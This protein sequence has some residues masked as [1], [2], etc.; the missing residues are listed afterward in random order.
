MI[1]KM[2]KNYIIEGI[3]N[4]LKTKKKRYTKESFYY[5]YKEFKNFSYKVIN[6]IPIFLSKIKD[7]NLNLKNS[8]ITIDNEGTFL[9]YDNKIFIK[10]RKNRDNKFIIDFIKI[11][12]S[13]FDK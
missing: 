8:T 5:E 12:D 7:I 2:D 13:I 9:N 10:L 11:S 6:K 3:T 4:T 1:N